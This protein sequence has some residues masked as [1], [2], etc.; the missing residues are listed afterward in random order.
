[1]NTISSTIKAAQQKFIGLENSADFL[2]RYRPA[3]YVLDGVMQTG[4]TYAL[5]GFTGHAKTSATLYL[6]LCILNGWDFGPHEVE[7]GSVLFLAGENPSNV[8]SQWLAL[9]DYH[10][11]NARHPNMH[12]HYG[13]FD[14]GACQDPMQSQAREIPNL[15]LVV[16]DTLQAFFAGGS[17]NDNT[18]MIDAA[19]TF[20]KL[21]DIQ[22]RPA[23]LIPAHPSGKKPDRHNLVPRGGGAFLNEIDGNLTIWNDGEGT[24]Y[25]GSQGKHRGAPFDRFSL[26]LAEHG[27]CKALKDKRGRIPVI[28]VVGNITASELRAK[29]I[30]VKSSE[31]ALLRHIREYP[32]ATQNERAAD[33]GIAQATVSKRETHLKEAKAVEKVW[34]KLK[35]TKIG[36]E[37]LADAEEAENAL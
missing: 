19:R 37:A 22:T 17:D 16:A 18:E 3:E 9:C 7:A 30:E 15:R 12:W 4:M 14:I 32:V 29:A 21:G 35:L 28:G 36:R 23:V 26:K 33:L 13:Y 8:M 25:W 11:A 10:G 1:M 20:R 34:H 31:I 5:T 6:C 2:S 24:L 27:K